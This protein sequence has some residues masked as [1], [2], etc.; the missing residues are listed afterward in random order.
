MKKRFLSRVQVRY[1]QKRFPENLIPRKRLK[2]TSKQTQGGD[3]ISTSL[4]RS[5]TLS[6]QLRR[7][8]K[9]IYQRRLAINCSTSLEID[10]L[11]RGSLVAFSPEGGG[12]PGG[13]PSFLSKI[14][15][16]S[17]NYPS[18]SLHLFASPM[19]RRWWPTLQATCVSASE[20]QRNTNLKACVGNTRKHKRNLIPNHLSFV[21]IRG[22]KVVSL[23]SSS[24]LEGALSRQ[25]EKRSSTLLVQLMER[26]KLRILYGNLSNREMN[27]LIIKAIKGR[28]RFGDILFRLLE[29]RLDVVL[30]KTGF[31]PTIPFARQWI[32]HGKV[33]VNNKVITLANYILQP[34]DI[35][36]MARVYRHLVKNHIDEK[37]DA[38]ST[39]LSRRSKFQFQSGGETDYSSLLAKTN[40]RTVPWH[41]CYR[42]LESIAS[43]W[44]VVDLEPQNRGK[45]CSIP[46]IKDNL[47]T[48]SRVMSHHRNREDAA[49]FSS[50]QL[51]LAHLVGDFGS[52]SSL[53]LRCTAKA[54]HRIPGH[55]IDKDKSHLATRQFKQEFVKSKLR[56]FS[57]KLPHVEI[58]FKLLQ[59]VYLYP[60]QRVFFPAT[61]DIEK[62]LSA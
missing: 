32:Y 23:Y 52:N 57:P 2:K 17:K 40:S 15:I 20:M 39:Y 62:I 25:Q 16:Q 3:Q 45:D 61:I 38:L 56:V 24:Q 27:T 48:V 18:D 28:G 6:P 14:W 9:S 1:L 47:Q 7:G 41:H 51:T 50:T 4:E 8:A 44:S 42:V 55:E 22:K 34:G 11:E 54:G 5:F 35:I 30:Y 58:S 46:S 29:S 53:H 10:T 33:L 21:G 59:V 26:K 60:T 37:I 19:H 12:P 43:S 49:D 36:S 31:L 13:P